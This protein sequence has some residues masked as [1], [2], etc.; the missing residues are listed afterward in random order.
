[1]FYLILSYI[2]AFGVG[3]FYISKTENVVDTG[4]VKTGKL[5][6]YI[7]GNVVF[8]S[9]I[10]GVAGLGHSEKFGKSCLGHIGIFP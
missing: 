1:M 6:Q 8:S 4:V 2:F 3:F 9:F 7:G 5:D 10:F